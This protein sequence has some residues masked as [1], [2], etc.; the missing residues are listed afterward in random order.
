[1][2]ENF[3]LMQLLG[4]YLCYE[5]INNVLKK[6]SKYNHFHKCTVFKKFSLSKLEVS[7]L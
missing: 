7:N 6:T 3:P 1:M 5:K 2:K 4:K